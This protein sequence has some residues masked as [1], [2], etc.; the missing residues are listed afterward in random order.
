L[1]TIDQVNGLIYNKDSL[2]YGTNIEHK[3]FFVME[4]DSPYGVFN[5]EITEFEA[6]TVITVADTI[7]FS[8]PVTIKVIAAD[9][10]STKTY[11]AQLNVHQVNPDTMIWERYTNLIPGKTFQEMKVILYRDAYYMYALENTAYRLYKAE[12]T[13]VIDWNELTLTGFPELAVMSQ[14]MELDGA[15]YLITE[16]GRLYRAAEGQHWEHVPMDMPI[17]TIYGFL[18]ANPITGRN[19]VLCCVARIDDASV[20]VTIDKQLQIITGKAVPA[21]IPVSAFGQFHYQTMHHP[22][23]VI[24]AGRDSRSLLSNMAFATMDGLSWS[25]LSSAYNAFSMR[26]GAAVSFYGN[27]FAVIGG[28]SDTGDGLK[29]FYFSLDQGINWVRTYFVLLEKEYE[30]DEDVYEERPFYPLDDD[31]LARGFSS[32]IIDKNNYMLLF[33]GKAKKDTHVM[34]ELWRGR[35]NRLGFGKEE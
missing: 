27:S 15:L 5:V 24:A 34:N 4:Y 3:V 14:M 6:D 20:F 32:V 19:D 30:D 9:E 7:D 2:P 1:F 25:S 8:K 18:P 11:L 29:D 12:T 35:I 22:R 26:E 16:R 17:T 31:Y 23:L 10:N 28:I 21:S 33:G 13:N